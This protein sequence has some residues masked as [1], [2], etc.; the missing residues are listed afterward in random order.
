M[1]DGLWNEA[2]F[3]DEPGSMHLGSKLPNWYVASH[4]FPERT[5]TAGQRAS[6]N[7][8]TLC[9]LSQPLAE[10]TGVGCNWK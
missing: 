8:P 9:L 5:T 2:P 1:N 10:G 6:E 3:T 4:D 7:P